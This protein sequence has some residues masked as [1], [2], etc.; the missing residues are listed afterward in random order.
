M[1]HD[2]AGLDPP[3]AKKLC[4]R[5][6]H[7]EE[8][9][10]HIAG[11]IEQFGGRSAEEYITERNA[12]LGVY[13][14]GAVVNGGLEQSFSL[15]KLPPHPRVLRTLTG[16]QKRHFRSALMLNLTSCQ[17]IRDMISSPCFY[18]FLDIALPLADN[19][20]AVAH[21]G[22]AG[23]GRESDVAKRGRRI[24]LEEGRP[25]VGQI[26]QSS[27]RLG[28]QDD[29]FP[30]TACRRLRIEARICCF[31]ED[32]VGVSAA[33]A[34]RIDSRKPKSSAAWPGNGHGRHFDRGMKKI[35]V[36]IQASKM[37]T[38]KDCFLIER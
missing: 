31:L 2:H 21:M 34:E 13:K 15:V 16:E 1:A 27:S 6:F 10:L 8:C 20:Q 29:E 23:G 37:E 3:L 17:A 18:L 5:I 38:W 24:V 36:G 12:E 4:Q 11:I 32:G 26:L 7:G 22:T 14:G 30:W 25:S 19:G 33:V 9:G 28:R 35:D